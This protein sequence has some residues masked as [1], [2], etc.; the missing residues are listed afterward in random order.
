MK[1]KKIKYEFILLGIG[2]ILVGLGGIAIKFSLFYFYI[3]LLM[4]GIISI[5]ISITSLLIGVSK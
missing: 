1:Y 5:D 2:I 4:Y 3:P